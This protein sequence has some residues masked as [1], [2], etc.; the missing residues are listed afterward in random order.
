[1]KGNQKAGGLCSCNV[2]FPRHCSRRMR[3]MTRG[4]KK[5]SETGIL[6]WKLDAPSQEDITNRVIDCTHHFSKFSLIQSI[7]I[8]G[9]GTSCNVAK[10]CSI[11]ES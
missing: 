8:K 7:F 11:R 4:K 6:C 5:N 3:A 2:E 9:T 10:S 1:M